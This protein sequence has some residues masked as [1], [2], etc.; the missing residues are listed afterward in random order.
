[1]RIS[2]YPRPCSV[3]KSF[4]RTSSAE[5]TLRPQISNPFE[6]GWNRQIF[7]TAEKFG[8]GLHAR[9]SMI[10]NLAWHPPS[11]HLFKSYRNIY[12]PDRPTRKSAK[13]ISQSVSL[14][15]HP[16]SNLP[17]DT[18]SSSAPAEPHTNSSLLHHDPRL[19]F[20]REQKRR[21]GSAC[22]EVL[23]L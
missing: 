17:I 14:V 11:H 23:R 10:I 2:A 1:M 8:L 7:K 15:P 22:E 20:L 13:C 6:R 3:N 9:T 12:M 18:Y 16:P 5:H 19:F 21:Q 4:P